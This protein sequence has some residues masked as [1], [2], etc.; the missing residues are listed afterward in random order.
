MNSLVLDFK[1][2]PDSFGDLSSLEDLSLRGCCEWV[3]DE[4]LSELSVSGK[5]KS[6]SLFR[7]WRLMDTGLTSFLKTN[8]STLRFLE[9]AG[10][11]KVTDI[12]LQAIARFCPELRHLDLTRCPLITDVGLNYIASPELEVLL[13]YADSHLTSSSYDAIGECT[14][15]RKL[16]LCGHSNLDSPRLIRILQACGS[17]LEYLN[18]SWCVELSDEIID[19][20]VGEKSLPQIHYLSLFGIKNLTKVDLLVEYLATIP[21]ITHLDVRG[22][23]T[24]FQL[25]TDDCYE[26]RKRI[27]KLL[28]WKLHH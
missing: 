4:V 17:T 13:L 8:G 16:D 27:P 21:S 9:L 15:L 6:V 24:A 25:T 12:T 26:L 28:E 19:F 23:P 22:I 18:L 14:S 2:K 1:D 11:T 7:C 5:I 10:C 3:T 20:I